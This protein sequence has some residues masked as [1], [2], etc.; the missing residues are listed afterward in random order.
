MPLAKSSFPGVLL[1]F[2]TGADGVGG[3]CVA[4]VLPY[5]RVSNSGRPGR[6]LARVN[7]VRISASLASL[8]GV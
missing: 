7:P 6:E 1:G 5:V 8:T 4:H 3:W 2:Q